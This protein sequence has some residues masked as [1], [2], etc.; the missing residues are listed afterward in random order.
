MSF[1]PVLKGFNSPFIQHPRESRQIHEAWARLASS[2][3]FEEFNAPVLE[4]LEL[5]RRKSGKAI[6]EQ[7]FAFQ[8]KRGRQV[9]LRPELTPSLARLVAGNKH[10]RTWPWRV[11][12]VAECYRY[13]RPQKGRLR[14]FYQFNADVVG[15]ALSDKVDT[16]L[17]LVESFRLFNLDASAFKVRLSSRDVWEVYLKLLGLVDASD[18]KAALEILDRFD[19]VE[20]ALRLEKLKEVK[21]VEP[22]KRAGFLRQLDEFRKQDSLESISASLGDAGDEAM[23]PLEAFFSACQAQGDLKDFLQVD[24]KV[25]RGL[26]YYTGLVF[27]VFADKGRALAGGGQYRGLVG[28]LEGKEGTE[29]E[30]PEPWNC[31]F[32]FAVG[33]PT[34]VQLLKERNLRPF[35]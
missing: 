35:N 28:A 20:E 8:D 12:S 32:G 18:R 26:D 17:L 33:E 24:L 10:A 5:Y 13:E 19:R 6:E 22:A 29:K 1:P 11:F 25:V 14:A 23:K 21:N 31:G 4:P 9:A 30:V 16:L 15:G 27:E 34:L 3:G 7:L 2:S